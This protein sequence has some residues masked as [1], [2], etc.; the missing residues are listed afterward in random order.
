MKQGIV[1]KYSFT[2][3]GGIIEPDNDKEPNA[4]FSTE[5]L[6]QNGINDIW[7]GVKVKYLLRQDPDVPHRVSVWKIELIDDFLVDLPF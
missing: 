3:G 6:K 4:Y 2:K 1:R 7:P 5:T